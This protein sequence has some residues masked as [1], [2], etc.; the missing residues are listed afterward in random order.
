MADFALQQCQRPDAE[1][2]AAIQYPSTP[3]ALV[4]EAIRGPRIGELTE[5]RQRRL[6][7][8]RGHANSRRNDG[9]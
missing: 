6:D 2:S 7:E 4:D 5:G 1:A 3:G 8:V 9:G